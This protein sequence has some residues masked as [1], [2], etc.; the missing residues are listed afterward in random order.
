MYPRLFENPNAL[1]IE[2][3]GAMDWTE[4][5]NIPFSYYNNK[6]Y[7][8]R[9]GE[10]HAEMAEQH[11]NS[12]NE[13][14]E[15]RGQYSGRIFVNEKI[16]TF[17]HFPEN[18]QTLLKVLKDITEWIQSHN[19]YDES[20]KK[21]NFSN[22]EWTV[23]IPTMD[24]QHFEQMKDYDEAR[25][26]KMWKQNWNPTKNDQEFIPIK[27][28]NGEYERSEEE[29][30]IRHKELPIIGKKPVIPGYG[31]KNPKYQSRRQWDMATLGHESK[32]ENNFYP[33]INENKGKI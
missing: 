27:N 2:G 23:E 18:K 11:I 8:G 13:F 19:Y 29:L 6:I 20:I 21:I 9:N 33:R 26:N 25:Y 32:E 22:P 31:S 28:Y 17:W 4:F 1:Y 12:Y 7:C 5:K 15:A 16:I 30:K 14:S 24:W 3:E 10:T